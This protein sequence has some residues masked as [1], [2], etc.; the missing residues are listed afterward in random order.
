MLGHMEN[1][2]MIGDS[3]HDVTK[4]KS[5]LTNLVAFYEMVAA[6][7]D[8][9]R[10]TD[11]IYLD[12]CKAFNTV[13]HIILV[14]TLKGHRWTCT[15]LMKFNK[16]KYKVLHLG[17]DN[18]KHMYR[19]GGEWIK[20]SPKKDLEMSVYEKLD[21]TK[22]SVLAAQKANHVLGSIKSHMASRLREVILLFFS[23]LM[24]PHRE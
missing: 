16:A 19:L 21:M 17:Q 15:N 2:E 20:A 4:G 10:A 1:K 8:E 18:P 23:A 5:S 24:R 12:L 7:V 11:T 3:Q 6:V 14:S 22:Q 9:Q 13:L